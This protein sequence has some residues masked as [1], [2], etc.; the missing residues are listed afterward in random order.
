MKYLQNWLFKATRSRECC[1]LGLSFI[2][3]VEIQQKLRRSFGKMNNWN[4]GGISSDC[5]R[6]LSLLESYSMHRAWIFQGLHDNETGVRIEYWQTLKPCS[7]A[8]RT[9]YWHLGP[10]LSNSQYSCQ[11]LLL[12]FDFVF[13]CFIVSDK[14]PNRPRLASSDSKLN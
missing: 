3:I 10:V 11:V 2:K 12:K 1:R 8:H 14:I 5:P 4:W 7:I 9:T 13:Y 6:L